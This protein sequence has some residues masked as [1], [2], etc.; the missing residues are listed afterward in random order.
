MDKIY[1]FII[2]AGLLALFITAIVMCC[3]KSTFG[4]DEVSPIDNNKTTS[5]T[6]FIFYAPWC[7]HCVNA[8]DEFEKAEQ[9]GNGKIKLVDATDTKNQD[10]VEKYKVNGFPTIVK[11]DGS[12]FSGS[13][14]AESIVAFANEK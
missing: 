4:A 7:G 10:L 1:Q 8:K 6:V 2:A 5:D 3:K 9:M 13:R 14:T 11:A 12:K